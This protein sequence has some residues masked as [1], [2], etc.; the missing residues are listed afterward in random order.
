MITRSSDKLKAPHADSSPSV[1]SAD[2]SST[3]WSSDYGEHYHS[4]RDGALSESLAKHVLPALEHTDA[5]QRDQLNVLDICYGLG[6]NSLCLVHELRR[7]QWPGRLRILSPEMDIGLLASLPERPLPPALAQLQDIQRQIAR[8]HAWED[9][10]MRIDVIPDNALHV[11]QDCSRRFDIVFQDAFSPARNPELWTLEYFGL[12]RPL[13]AEQGILTTYSSATP[14]R[15]AMHAQG[16]LLYQTPAVQELH[17]RPGTLASPGALAHLQP[18]DMHAKAARAT[19]RPYRDPQLRGNRDAIF[20]IAQ[21]R[22]H[23]S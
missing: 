11:L 14:V 1:P 19:S 6:Y 8:N 9:R 5:L 15:L 7:R 17:V 3:A 10:S 12:L 4:T 20:Q 18:I 13:L 23:S 16:W 2:G 21:A 22:N